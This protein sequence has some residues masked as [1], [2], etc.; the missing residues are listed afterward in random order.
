[1]SRTQPHANL[2]GR[3]VAALLAMTGSTVLA[4]EA[5]QS[6]GW[7]V[8]ARGLT[9]S[10]LGRRVAALLAMTRSSVLASGAKQSRSRALAATL[11]HANPLGRRVAALL[12]M[13]GKLDRARG[14]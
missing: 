10:S 13:T 2:L 11:P 12:A 4:S 8:A 14:R 9:P 1:M 5:K 3:R 7:A 6:R